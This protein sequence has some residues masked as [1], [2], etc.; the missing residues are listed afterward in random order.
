MNL[1][2]TPRARLPRSLN[3][4]GTDTGQ[5]ALCDFLLSFHSNLWP[6]L[7]RFRDKRR[8]RSKI[9]KFS[10]RVHLTL[11]LSGFRLEFGNTGWP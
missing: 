7:Y 5:S 6:I 3:V 8:F 10:N 2:L 1:N 4:F 9:A 11:P